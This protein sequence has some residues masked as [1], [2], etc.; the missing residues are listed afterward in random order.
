MK[1]C[2]KRLEERSVRQE[3]NGGRSRVLA[4]PAGPGGSSVA[5]VGSGEPPWVAG[6][7]LRPP[8]LRLLCFPTE[9]VITPAWRSRMWTA[10]AMLWRSLVPICWCPLPALPSCWRCPAQHPP[11]MAL[12]RCGPRGC[13]HRDIGTAMWRH[14]FPADLDSDACAAGVTPL[15]YRGDG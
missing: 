4:T 10:Q 7:A 5:A 3:G 15:H 13:Q 8:H 6:G 12:P 2:S 11:G 1:K 9:Q 14:S